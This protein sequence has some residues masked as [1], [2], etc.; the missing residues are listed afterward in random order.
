MSIPSPRRL[1]PRGR[2]FLSLR[3]WSTGYT[4]PRLH[5]GTIAIRDRGN[6]GREVT[7]AKDCVA[8]WL[9]STPQL[10]RKD[11]HCLLHCDSGTTHLL[12]IRLIPCQ[13]TLS[14]CF[15]PKNDIIFPC[16]GLAPLPLATLTAGFFLGTG[17]SSE[18][19]S[20]V[21][22]SRVTVPISISLVV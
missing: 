4:F 11:R 3:P 19:D 13:V 12:E 7:L 20:H 9:H 1:R 6:I 15:L 16:P 17:S 2:T 5:A 10:R 8:F 22:S 14:Y 18:K 21:A